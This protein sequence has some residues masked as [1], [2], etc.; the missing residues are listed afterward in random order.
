VEEYFAH[1]EQA[2]ASCPLVD[3]IS[4][5]RPKITKQNQQWTFAYWK[6]TIK[7]S[8]GHELRVVEIYRC[9]NDGAIARYFNYHFMDANRSCIFRFDA[10]GRGI[11]DGDACHLHVGANEMVIEEGHIW[12]QRLD[13]RK[14]DFRVVFHLAVRHLKGKALPW[15]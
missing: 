14:L 15:E 1:V 12:A 13:L 10:H 8:T 6:A 9:A 4:S 3:E 5:E 2:L 11:R 7:F